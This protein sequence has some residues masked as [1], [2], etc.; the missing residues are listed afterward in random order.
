VLSGFMHKAKT[1]YKG[2]DK[3]QS[4]IYISGKGAIASILG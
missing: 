4:L 1:V 2:N 3:R